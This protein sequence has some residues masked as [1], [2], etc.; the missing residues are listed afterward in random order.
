MAQPTGKL[1]FAY[2]TIAN[3]E[4]KIIELKKKTQWFDP[5][6][7]LPAGHERV[8]AVLNGEVIVLELQEETPTY[9]E[10]FK[11][12]FYWHEPF[13]E[14]MQIEWHEVTSW[15]HLP[16]VLTPITQK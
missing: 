8:I 1:K 11:P 2:E 4:S 7:E 13:D 16:E 15:M 12:F 3:M 6:V 10:N 5:N 14:Y 9:E